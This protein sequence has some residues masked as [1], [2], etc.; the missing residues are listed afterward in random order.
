MKYN[1]K[2]GAF[3]MGFLTLTYTI[4]LTNTALTLIS[5]NEP[6]AR[7]MGFLILVFPAF[8]LWTTIREFIFGF[9]IEKL[10]TKIEK[11]GNW[12]IFEFEYR[13]SGRPTRESA[14]RVFETYAETAKREPESVLAWFSLGLAYDAAGDRTR[15]RRAMRKAL[16]LDAKASL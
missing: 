4:L 7:L 13:P 15:A 10:A 12:P 16:A 2:L 8:A 9:K 14:D 6:V 11:A 1:A 5:V 3:F